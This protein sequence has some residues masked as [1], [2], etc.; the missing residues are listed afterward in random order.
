M[1]LN[2]LT[3]LAADPKQGGTV[4][5]IMMGAIILV[6]WLFMIRPQA[7]KAKEQKKFIDNLSKGDKIVTIAGIHGIVNKI[8]EDGTL[9]LEVTPGSYLKIEKSAL[10]ME[11][12]AAIN[13]PVVEEKK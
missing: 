11:W 8:N 2:A 3:I 13:K 1:L 7:K 4:Q 10:S 12:T 6:F 5:L 9:Q